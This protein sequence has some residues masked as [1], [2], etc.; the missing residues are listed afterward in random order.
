MVRLVI[1]RILESYFRHRWL[2]LLPIVLMTALGA[3]FVLLTKPTYTAKGVLYVETQ[4]YLA[5]LTDLRESGVSWWTTPAESVNQE[6]SELLQTDAFVRAIIQ[7]TSLEEQMDQGSPV[8]DTLI[9][10][11]RNNVWPT[12]LG[13]NQLQVNAVHEDPEVAYQIVT[14]V[15]EGYLQW[16]VNADLAESEVAQSFFADLIETYSVDL[17]AARDAMRSYVAAHPVPLRGDRPADET[18]EISRLQGEIDL[19]A[20]RYATALDK[21]EETRLA[22]AQIESDA[23]QTYFLIDAPTVPEKPDTSLRKMA[24]SGGIFTVIGVF[25]SAG[26]IVGVALID[27][28]FR[29]P[30]DVINRLELPVL[31]MVPEVKIPPA[32]T[33]RQPAVK[34]AA[35]E[36]ASSVG[37]EPSAQPQVQAVEEFKSRKVINKKLDMADAA[38]H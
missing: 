23:R 38:V 6:I 11:T 9:A 17:A 27:R 16:R 37:I 15:I 8:V 22:M 25:L 14:A 4:S 30:I 24:L 28:S 12:P 21:E 20:S 34:P 10:E 1:L 7:R 26:L 36:T 29:F 19:A 35:E 33:E 13:N 2:Y 3:V 18:M 5:S 32:S 31:T